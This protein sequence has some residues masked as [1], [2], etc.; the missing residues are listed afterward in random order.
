LEGTYQYHF[1]K[2][3]NYF[4]YPIA[5]ARFPRLSEIHS[6]LR[7]ESQVGQAFKTYVSRAQP[8]TGQKVKAL[9]CNGSGEHKAGRL[10]EAP[11]HAVPLHDASPT[12]ALG[13]FTL[14]EAFSGNKPDVFRLR[15]LSCKVSMHPENMRGKLDTRSLT[16]TFLGLAHNNSACHLVHKPSCLLI[17]SHTVVLDEGGP[18]HHHHYI[19]HIILD[20]DGLQ[21][22]PTSRLPLLSHRRPMATP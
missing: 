18:T 13:F 21:P 7:D 5:Q 6:A 8:S 20:H 1:Y 16:R 4:S 9:L 3:L 10:Q 2:Y 17:G 19:L 14:E 15:A 12:H 22:R 11:R